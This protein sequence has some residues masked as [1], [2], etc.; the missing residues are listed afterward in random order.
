MHDESPGAFQNATLDAMR[1]A[2][3]LAFFTHGGQK[4][5]GWFGGFGQSGTAEL[6]TRFGAA[7]VIEV[8]AGTL[9]VLGLFTRPAAFIASGEMAAAY[10]WAH[11]AGQGEMW[12]W[13]NGGELALLYCFVWL[14][15][16]ARGAGPFS[17]DAVLRR[18]S[19]A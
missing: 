18:R 19:E 13:E 11:W 4:I 16:A 17:L 8:V 9:L 12:W 14:F 5:F 6:M 2:V 10:I 15:F 1:I 7:G 3:G